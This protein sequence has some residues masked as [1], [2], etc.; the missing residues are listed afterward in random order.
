MGKAADKLTLTAD[1]R[2]KKILE[3]SK[4]LVASRT[5][6][7]ELYKAKTQQLDL[8]N[9]VVDSK[10]KSQ[11]AIQKKR[12]DAIQQQEKEHQ[13]RM[14]TLTQKTAAASSQENL[15]QAK[16]DRQFQLMRNGNIKLEM[17]QQRH[18]AQM[19]RMSRQSAMPLDFDGSQSHSFLD[20][21]K[22]AA[23]H[24]T[25]FHG[26]Y[27]AINEA[28]EALKVGLVD[29]EANMAGYVQTNENY[30]VSW[31]KG[32]TEMV[33]NTERLHA[34]TTKFIHTA[35][36][37]GAEITDVTESA[38]LWGRMYKDVGIVQE[39]V[40]A[41]TKLS[42]V[43][44]VELEDATKGMES[45]FAQYGVQIHNVNDAMVMGNRVLD[46]WSKVAHDTM[47]PAKDLAAAF[48][49]TGKIAD[50]TGV[51]FDFMNGLISAGVRN[52]ALGGANLGNMWKTVFG[53][54]RT[55]KAVSEIERL[56]VA[57]KEVVNGTEQWRKAED[58]LLDLSVKVTDKNYDLTQSY[59]DISRGVYQYAKLA[60]SL[61]AG[62]ILLGTA[63]SIG[64]TGSTMEYLK[65]QMDTIQRKAAQTKA[66]L[67]EIFNQAG[68]DGLRSAIK[69]ALDIL[70]QLLIGFTKVPKEIFTLSA[71]IA[72]LIV[73]YKN[74]VQPLVMWKTAQEAL[75]VA[76]RINTVV[77]NAETIAMT[78]QAAAARN[79]AMM[80]ALATGGITLLTG[81]IA[82]SL[83]YM[84]SS[85]KA[86]R[87]H[88][89]ALKDEDSAAQQMISQYQ[90]QQELIPKLANAHN[91]LQGML[92][93]GTLSADKEA[94]VKKQLD[95]ISKALTI[96]LGEEGAA[97]LQA[98][99]YT[100]EAV[101]KQIAVLDELIAKQNEA[102]KNVLLD[103][104]KEI[105][106][107]QKQKLKEL[108]AAKDELLGAQITSGIT[109]GEVG[110][111]MTA[112]L[113]KAQQ[114]VQD[115]TTDN[116]KLTDALAGV[117]V[118]L[119]E[120]EV[121]KVDQLAGSSKKSAEAAQDA[122]DQLKD[123]Q[124]QLKDAESAI[125]DLN[126]VSLDMAAGHSLNAQKVAQLIH[127]YPQLASQ[128]H[129]TK[130]GWVVE[131][132]AV[133]DIKNAKI[134]LAVKSAQ[135]QSSMTSDAFKGMEDRIGAYDIEIQKIMDLKSAMIEAEKVPTVVPPYLRNMGD[136]P[137][138]LGGRLAEDDALRAAIIAAGEA[139]EKTK[140][141]ARGSLQR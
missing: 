12:Q 35:H 86:H 53:T 16:I 59:A 102:R 11:Q 52:T 109:A 43:D 84:G 60:A 13:Q 5:A 127:D 78:A 24:A 94:K 32:H 92:E 135:A 113:E 30:F 87:D 26:V 79:A 6:Q 95:D 124:T 10:L 91:S 121:E 125:A 119:G 96:T 99:N 120:M 72:G 70:D 136:A 36:D 21:V 56:G 74:V 66:S 69:D 115:L 100:D 112:Q 63:A 111:Q 131:K 34:E 106:D 128:I 126:Q 3:E 122:A 132:G 28:Q 58:I 114:K 117:N 141:S 90:R 82:A 133:N 4:A 130:D 89:Q 42:T 73:L 83:L 75:T 107:Q 22:S 140:K 64:S 116:N 46:S 110:V 80:T 103:Q 104:R 57:T 67:L 18:A 8:T 7:A 33:M 27:T 41:S 31:N 38:R 23:L 37:L 138:A 108:E 45:V 29:I 50:E 17:E 48:E 25:V 71:S 105:E 97:H 39:M 9:Q 47:A 123:L 51:S 101:K 77:T 2:R 49:R 55:D 129:K 15:A 44:L 40:R 1:E 19:E 14:A 98:A 118:Q 88:I 93:K 137:D 68:D 139:R 65:V 20:K 76:M 134:E 62:D 85:E 61:N 54:I 81:A